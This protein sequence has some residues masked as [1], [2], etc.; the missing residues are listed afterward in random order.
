M[1]AKKQTAWEKERYRSKGGSQCYILLD[2]CDF[3][4]RILSIPDLTLA[5]G[6]TSDIL[7]TLDNV[8]GV[9]KLEFDLYYD[10]DLLDITAVDRN[11]SLPAS[12]QLTERII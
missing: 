12:W 5:P 7:V 2:C 8:E 9:T 11:S 3:G 10:S 1:I 4:G 6:A